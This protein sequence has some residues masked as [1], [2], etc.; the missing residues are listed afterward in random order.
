M[1]MLNNGGVG[2]GGG[3]SQFHLQ[4]KSRSSSI[5]LVTRGR[6][7]CRLQKE[8]KY[9]NNFFYF[10]EGWGD[11][12]I[13]TVARYTLQVTSKRIALIAC[14]SC[15]QVKPRVLLAKDIRDWGCLALK[16]ITFYKH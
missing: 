10:C 5:I 4:E 16:A 9:F 2:G 11:Q 1:P 3:W 8:R 15:I 12:K 6:E 14:K 7:I 13:C